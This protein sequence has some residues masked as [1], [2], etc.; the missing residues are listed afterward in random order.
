MRRFGQ[1]A[2]QLDAG[3]A[4]IGN[5]P[6]ERLRW[7]LRFSSRTRKELAAAT[8]AALVALEAEVWAFALFVGAR[9]EMTTRDPDSPPLPSDIA[10][11][12]EE[13]AR[14]MNVLC[15]P[16]PHLNTGWVVEP[17]K[18]GNW[19][20]RITPD[21]RS[22]YGGNYRPVFLMAASDLLTAEG[23]RI[24]SCGHCSQLFVRRKR[25][26]YCSTACSQKARTDRYRAALGEERWREKRHGHYVRLIEQQKGKKVAAKVKMRPRKEL[27]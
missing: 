18:F 24:A 27:D 20:R 5:T 21:F 8:Q 23:H 22:W 6:I 10:D 11:L 16:E 25:G 2:D 9:G 3:R 12:A 17:S 13:V 1:L 26:A 4:R 15:S 14:G 19:F 7:L